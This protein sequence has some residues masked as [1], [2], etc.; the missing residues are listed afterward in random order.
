M[1][2]KQDNQSS[3]H[4]SFFSFSPSLISSKVPSDHTTTST[5]RLFPNSCA[6]T[7]SDWRF[8]GFVILFLTHFLPLTAL[9]ESSPIPWSSLP[10]WCWYLI[11]VVV[12]R[13]TIFIVSNKMVKYVFSSYLYVRLDF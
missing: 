5:W 4:T 13:H 6:A 12:I 10:Y 9:E 8:V 7:L 1:L 3:L 11:Y 2:L